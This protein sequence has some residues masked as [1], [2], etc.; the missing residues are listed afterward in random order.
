[1]QSSQFITFFTAH[2]QLALLFL[3]CLLLL[4]GT[5]IRNRLF[6]V[7]QLSPLEVTQAMNRQAAI[8]LDL[9]NQDPFS[10]GHILG[11]VNRPWSE[12][13]K[14]IAALNFDKQKPIITICEHGQTAS[15]AAAMLRKAGFIQPG[16]LRGG[17]TAWKSAGLP[18]AKKGGK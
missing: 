2:W 16:S 4:L 5:E 10:Q 18:L 7:P 14:H 6:G 8:L 1:M 3:T 17:M 13:V 9:R 15:K 12:F 11:A